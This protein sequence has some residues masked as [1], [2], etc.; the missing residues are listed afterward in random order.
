MKLRQL[1]EEFQVEER[2]N[3]QPGSDGAYAF[4]RMEKRSWSTPDALAA[5]R[6]RW[7]IEPRRISYGGLKD[8]HSLSVQ[9]FTIFHGPRRRL[10]HAGVSVVY[11]GQLGSPYTSRD[12]QANAFRLTLRSVDPDAKPVM[13]QAL[14]HVRRQGVPNYFDDQR[15]GS[16]RPDGESVG[17]FLVLGQFEA[18]LKLALAGPYE[19]DRAPQKKEKAILREQW[20]DWKTL[21]TELPRGH[22]RSLVDFLV[23]HPTDFRGAIARLRPELRGLYLSAYQSH[24]WNRI[25]G[26]WLL[27]HCPAERL[28]TVRLR[29]GELP[30]FR[31]LPDA[32][33]KHLA[34]TILP[35]PSARAKLDD[36]D[37]R[38][39]AV[40][41]VLAEDGLQLKEL[42]V[43]GMRELFFSRGERQAVCV[44]GEL[45]WTWSDDERRKGRLKLELAF[46]LSRG[47]YATMIVKRV[48]AGG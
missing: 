31:E 47:S 7:R 22:A 3:V 42:K 37:P 40:R 17:R 5:V 29:T 34:E 28:F 32:T 1:P 20:G 13:E 44:P 46:N 26:R 25:L 36:T 8:R 48:Q 43:K 19:H 2:P 16:V 38:T 39:E 11:L 14:D 35:L 4:Y 41:A 10:H 45:C 18:A 9:Y 27:T 6:R 21:K 33:W 30:M 12:I 15:F 23:S 24:L